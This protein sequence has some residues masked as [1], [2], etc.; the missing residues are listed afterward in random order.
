[1]PEQLPQIPSP[2]STPATALADLRAEIDRAR[3][4]LASSNPALADGIKQL[5][6]PLLSRIEAA[7]AAPADLR[8]R[9][10]ELEDLLE[11]VL[12]TRP[13]QAFPDE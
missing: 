1:M 4:A 7:I 8:P 11:S 5:T 2:P 10:D 12:L 3:E 6:T 9:L 13:H